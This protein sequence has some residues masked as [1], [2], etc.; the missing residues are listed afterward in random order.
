MNLY[1]FKVQ[2]GPLHGSFISGGSNPEM[3]KFA[4]FT[5]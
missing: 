1:R 5:C 4:D 2:L 3:E